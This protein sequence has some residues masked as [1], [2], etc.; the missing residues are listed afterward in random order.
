MSASFDRRPIFAALLALSVSAAGA[1]GSDTPADYSHILPLSIGAHQAV[2]PLQ[3]PRAVYLAAHSPELHD[4]RVF[5]STG[6]AMPFALADLAPQA[7]VTRPTAPVAVFPV[8]GAGRAAG[9][10]PDGLQIRTGSDGTLISVTAPARTTGDE[11]ASLVLD[12]RPAAATAHPGAT[13][14]VGALVLALPPGTGN[15]DA[16]VALEVSNDLQ[17]WEQQAEAAVSWLVNDQG[18]SVGKHRIDF[19]P[20]P[21]RYAR[22]RWLDGKPIVFSGISA[23]YVVERQA[24]RQLESIVL[25]GTPGANGRD[26]LYTAPVAIP[27]R[28]LGLAFQGQNVVMPAMVGQYQ[29]TPQRAPGKPAAPQL[30][31]LVNTT[32]FQLEQD[33]KRRTSG[34]IAV[35]LTHAA[36]WVVRPLNGVSDRPQLRLQWE[37]ATIVFVA[38]GKAPYRLAFGRADARPASTA[39][40][41]VAPGF[42]ERELASLAMARPGELVQQQVAASKTAEAVP[43]AAGDQ[44]G[45]LWALLLVG[46]V[47]LAAMA[48]HLIRQLKNETPPPA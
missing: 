30:K 10:V 32:F 42:S 1:A 20:L 7:S 43:G 47:A 36:Q 13:A 40:H 39:L 31:P 22:I 23:E 27:V 15:Y 38:G 44:R 37:S 46:V 24:Q 8:H 34:D 29:S 26:L 4:L 16:R 2:V 41:Q 48:W 17:H 5:D 19:T 12:L 45:W 33:G 18:A 21:F 11:L 25:Q 14:P 35:P 9:Q 28:A 3:L 6:A